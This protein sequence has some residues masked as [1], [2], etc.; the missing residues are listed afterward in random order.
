MNY[1]L[2]ITTLT[3]MGGRMETHGI[4]IPLPKPMSIDEALIYLGHD[5]I[6]KKVKEYHSNTY[7]GYKSIK[8]RV[9]DTGVTLRLESSLGTRYVEFYYGIQRGS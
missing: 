2:S 6:R 8:T 3:S 1:S 9:R 7:G 4:S 5:K